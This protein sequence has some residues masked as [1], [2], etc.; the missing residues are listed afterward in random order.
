MKKNLVSAGILTYIAA[1]LLTMNSLAQS[2]LF[3][4]SF[5][6]SPVNPIVNS[7]DPAVDYT[8][9]TT[10][11]NLDAGGGTALI[12]EY[13][14]GDGMIKLLARNNPNTQTGNRTEVS[15]PLSAYNASFNPVLSAN[16]EILEWVF[17]AK[18]NR[19]STGGTTG[20]SGTQTGMAVVLASDSS[21]WATDQGS[22]ASGYAITFLKPEGSM[23]CV[24]LSR[25]D[26]GLS[27]YTVI[28]GNKTEDVFS[29]FRTWVTVK[30]TYQPST[31]E[32]RLF[33]RDEKSMVNKGNVFNSAG[34]K[35]IDIVVDDTFTDIRNEPFRVCP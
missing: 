12:E 5:N 34:M 19:N 29:E 30:V 28:A 14:P 2:V 35:L 17:T 33:F 20:F 26:G 1:V 15:A 6:Q 7:G 9:W 10:V 25:F 16:T 27:N 18:Q 23:Y 31:N 11:S 22:N 4:D 13:A 8:V 3:Y 21:V 24:S 32:W